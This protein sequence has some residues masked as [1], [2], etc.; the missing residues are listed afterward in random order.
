[1]KLKYN[2]LFCDIGG[3]LLT[4]GWGHKSRMAAAKKFDFDYEEMN[5]HHNFIFNVYEMGKITL[6]EYLDQVVFNQPRI[7][8]REVFKEFMFAQSELLP[9]MLPWFINWKK[10]HP[11]LKVISINNEARELNQFRIRKFRLH[12]FFDAFVSSCEVEMRKPDPE[13][14]ELALG[15]AQESPEKCL[16]LDDH[17]MLAEAASKIGIKGFHHERFEVTRD[18]FENLT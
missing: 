10:R 14:F 6:D 4:N 1:M 12:D 18:I 16:Y 7:F 15:I 9:D 2:V 5:I 3:V 8:S 17:V 13:I 11:H